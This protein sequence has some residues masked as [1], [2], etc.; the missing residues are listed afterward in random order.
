LLAIQFITRV[1]QT[2][3]VE[4]SVRALF[5]SPTLAGV[6]ETIT[7]LQANNEKLQVPAIMPIA[8]ESRRARWSEVRENIR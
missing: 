8:R 7:Q 2:W 6:A 1:R 3:Q 4:L 5:K